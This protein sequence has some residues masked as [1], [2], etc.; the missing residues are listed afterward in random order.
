MKE[1]EL[2]LERIEEI[3]GTFKTSML[4]TARR[5]VAVS[6]FPRA[7]VGMQWLDRLGSPSSTR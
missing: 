4:S 6:D 5:S 1:G 2:S 7:V 3:A